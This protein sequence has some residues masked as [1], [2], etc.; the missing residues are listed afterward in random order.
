MKIT[1]TA[2]K[3]NMGG[4]I[5]RAIQKR[6]GWEVVGVVGPKGRDYIGTDAGFVAKT[7]HALG[8]DV[9]DDG[10]EAVAACDVIIDFSTP[11]LSLEMARLAKKHKKAIVIGTTG[12]SEEQ[13]EELRAIS[14]EI[15]VLH[16]ANTSRMVHAFRSL[17]DV[18]VPLLENAD[19]EIIDM[20]DKKKADSP[21]GTALEMAHQIVELLGASFDDT[22]VFGRHAG[23]AYPKE[24]VGMHSV[25]AGDIPSTHTIV[26]GYP[27]ERLELTHHAV[28]MDGFAEGACDCA[29]FVHAK[30][31]GLYSVQ[32][33][34]KT[35]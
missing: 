32:E 2:P 7:G 14:K 22:V 19:I 18:A 17:L 25:R 20:H 8:V 30:E 31:P 6:D 28:N 34:F 29:A 9:T 10:D 21:S 4:A 26:F 15:P 35:K 27:G 16:A 3:G 12:L 1:V 5:L 23:E 24:S 11:T 13:R 33:A